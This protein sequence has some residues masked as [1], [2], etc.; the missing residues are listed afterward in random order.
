MLTKE[1]L[2]KYPFLKKASEYI[3]SLNLS[4][5]DFTDK[6][7]D[8]VERAL[9]R[10][11]FAVEGKLIKIDL[12]DPEKEILS[13]AVALALI[14]GLKNSWLIRRFANSEQ[15]LYYEM[16]A[17]EDDH[18]II[19]IAKDSFDWNLE[20]IKDNF[21]IPIEQFLEISPRFQAKEWK[22]INSYLD[23]GKIY[24]KKTKI[25]RLISEAVKNKIIKKSEE[26]EIKRLKLPEQLL[27]KAEIFESK[28]KKREIKEE[29]EEIRAPV[30][31]E[32]PPCISYIIKDMESGKA[33]SHMARFTVTSFL[34]NI[35]MSVEEILEYFRKV[36][37]FDENKARYQIQHIA[38][39]I[40]SKTKYLPPKCEV[41]K[42]FGICIEP[43]EIC[44]KIKHP[45]QYY[46]IMRKKKNV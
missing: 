36:A 32:L 43:N 24:L 16:L 12:Y 20:I 9:E 37:D 30:K 14:Y 22:L 8:I 46:K 31:E 13:Y 1:D 28:I 3:E 6:Y 11:K 18:K 15:K 39:M 38:G 41:L 19:E 25:A 33:I 5:N 40:G 10:I 45:L 4:I 27:C 7:S 21:M 17:M 26:E 23:N 29:Y 44:K 35:G 34:L 2:A 42:S